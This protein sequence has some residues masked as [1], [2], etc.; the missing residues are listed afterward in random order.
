MTNFPLFHAVILSTSVAL[1]P[2]QS[3]PNTSPYG[4]LAPDHPCRVEVDDAHISTDLKEKLGIDAVKVKGNS[5]CMYRTSHIQLTLSIMKEGLIEPHLVKT[6]RLNSSRTI[7]PYRL[8][9]LKDA[10]IKCK[11]KT[12]TRYFGIIQAHAIIKGRE[13]G[14]PQTRSQ[15]SPRIACGT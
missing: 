12:Q 10:F 7:L 6:F 9:E 3:N 4:L 11:N 8:F 14:T 2:M 13:Y 15:N 5:E 1:S